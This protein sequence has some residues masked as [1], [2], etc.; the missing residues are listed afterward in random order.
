MK[1]V[2]G[3]LDDTTFNMRVPVV[4]MKELIERHAGERT[5]DVSIPGGA[6]TMNNIYRWP[7]EVKGIQC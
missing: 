2:V 6:T 1:L 3:K 5:A 4:L 7:P